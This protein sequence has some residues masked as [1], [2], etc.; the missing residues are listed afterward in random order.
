MKR[1][2]SLL[3]VALGIGLGSCS[4]H[5]IIP[6]DKLAMIFRDAYLTNAY[7]SEYPLRLDSLMI[8]EP[9]F[10]AYGYTTEDVSYTI[11]N[12]SKRKSARLGDIVQQA[13]VLLNTEGNIYDAQVAVLDTIDNVA[14]RHFSRVIYSDSLIK[15]FTPRDTSRLHVTLKDIGT[16]EYEVS[17]NYLID[18]LDENG[19]QRT[20]IWIE[21]RDS[22]RM[23]YYTTSMRRSEPGRISTIIKSDT[24][25]RKLRINMGEYQSEFKT[26]HM[27]IK[28]LTVK[29]IP[30]TAIAL[31][32]LYHKQLDL[33]IF[34]DEFFSPLTTNSL[35]VPAKRGKAR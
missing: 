15:V 11:G 6:D 27:R 24:T 2:F 8:Y 19:Y 7:T 31:D 16:G 35:V 10:A 26:P 3:I 28:D 13:I 17:F 4:H 23:S 9:I 33:K 1:I 34:A 30:E 21:R 22:S 12:F 14:R 29:H 18:S 20:S 5:T 25:A 32:S